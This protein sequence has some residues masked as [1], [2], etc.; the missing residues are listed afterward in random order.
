[1]YYRRSSC[2]SLVHTSC[3]IQ[4]STFDI[5]VA[6]HIQNHCYIALWIIECMSRLHTMYIKM[7]IW[8][9]CLLICMYTEWQSSKPVVVILCTCIQ[10]WNILS[11]EL[12]FRADGEDECC[13][14]T[15][16][17]VNEYLGPCMHWSIV[18][19]DAK[20]VTYKSMEQIQSMIT[21]TS[22]LS[23]YSEVSIPDRYLVKFSHS[24]CLPEEDP[25]LSRCCCLDDS[26]CNP[27]LSTILTNNTHCDL[28]NTSQTDSPLS[29]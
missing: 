13:N 25:S 1:M 19:S 22:S 12:T 24:L 6:S 27:R 11:V 7:S 14:T 17:T 21:Q 5:V 29:L 16:H 26:L 9:K 10:I 8:C 2:S 4:L 20:R 28:L 23:I 3:V 18:R 15:L